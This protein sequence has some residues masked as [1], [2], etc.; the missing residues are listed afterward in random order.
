MGDVNARI[1]LWGLEGSGKTTTL[2]TIHAKLRED[3]RG[4]LRR[5]TTRLDPTVFFESL[6]I[7]LGEVGGVGTQLD[8][9]AVP[10]ASDQVMTRKQLLDEV[11]GI[12]LVL[13]CFEER[14]TTEL[15]YSV[16]NAAKMLFCG[17]FQTGVEPRSVFVHLVSSERSSERQGDGD[18]RSGGDS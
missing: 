7:T 9:I 5:E 14:L 16:R 8:L 10:G 12:V 2:E 1:L 4:P 17:I 6:S 13:D 15:F 18:E 11:D 3:L